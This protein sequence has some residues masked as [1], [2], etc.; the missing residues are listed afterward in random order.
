V[1]LFDEKQHSPRRSRC[2]EIR[3]KYM[4]NKNFRSE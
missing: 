2:A 1:L 3:L 4:V